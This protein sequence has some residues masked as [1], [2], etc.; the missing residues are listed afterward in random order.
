MDMIAGDKG[1]TLVLGSRGKSSGRWS[2]GEMVE[3]WNGL[4]KLLAERGAGH[5]FFL[6]Q[7]DLLLLFSGLGSGGG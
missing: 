3:H 2:Q 4:V 1:W 7:A 6:D 5:G